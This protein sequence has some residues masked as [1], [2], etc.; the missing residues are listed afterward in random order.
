MIPG[1]QFC[2]LLDDL[3]AAHVVTTDAHYVAVPDAA[4]AAPGHTLVLPRRISRRSGT[5]TTRP[6]PG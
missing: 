1:C 3:A 4:P 6:P 2:A 5:W